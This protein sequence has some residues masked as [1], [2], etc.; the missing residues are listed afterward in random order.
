[1]SSPLI[2]YIVVSTEMPI[3]RIDRCSQ[4]GSAKLRRS[5][6]TVPSGGSQKVEVEDSA[7]ILDRSRIRWF[8]STA[9]ASRECKYFS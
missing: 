1:M 8:G 6:T 2:P 7:A 3:G 5:E 9:S 4:L